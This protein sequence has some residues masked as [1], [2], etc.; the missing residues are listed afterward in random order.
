MDRGRDEGMLRVSAE[1]T[2][3]DGEMATYCNTDLGSGRDPETCQCP[4]SPGSC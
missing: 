3:N 1:A 2:E 4:F